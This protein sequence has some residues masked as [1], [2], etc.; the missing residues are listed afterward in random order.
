MVLALEAAYTFGVAIV[1]APLEV[2]AISWTSDYR[3][4]SAPVSTI[5][6]SPKFSELQLILNNPTSTRYED[7]DFIVRPDQPIAAIAE[8]TSIGGVHISEASPTSLTMGM[9]HGGTQKFEANPLVLIATD[10]GYRIRCDVLPPHEHVGIVMAIANID[11]SK[12]QRDKMTDQSDM[13]I[14]DRLYVTKISH[15]DGHASWF[16]NT[17]NGRRI[18]DVYGE[19]R[20][21]STV[22]I[23]G[24]YTSGPRRRSIKRHPIAAHDMLKDIINGVPKN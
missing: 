2:D 6:W 23:E 11:M 10:A 24:Q 7:V 16:G 18:D 1:P 14:H 20:P 12:S 15:G 17:D 21:V 19:K 4:G 22:Y 9:L 8:L 5:P 3:S 13:G